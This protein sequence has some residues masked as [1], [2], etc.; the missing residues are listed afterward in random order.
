MKT[1]LFAYKQLSRKDKTTYVF[2]M[3]MRLFASLLDMLGLALVGLAAS[4]LTGAAGPSNRIVALVE[5]GLVGAGFTN[6]Y[7]VFG[8]AA[9]IF[10]LI[11]AALSIW[12]NS[13]VAAFLARVETEQTLK[14]F[15]NLTRAGQG[16]LSKWS[17]KEIILAINENSYVAYNYSFMAG[18]IVFGEGFLLT[19][20]CCFLLFQNPVLFVA[21]ALYFMIFALIV[22]AFVGRRTKVAAKAVNTSTVNTQSLLQDYLSSS[23]QVKVLG[24]STSF[25]ALYRKERHF[26]AAS[27]GVLNKLTYL[28]RYI[29]ETA[30]MLG[31]AIILLQRSMD[32]GVTLPASTVAVFVA[33]AF[34]LIASLL[35]LQASFAALKTVDAQAELTFNL[36]QAIA[37]PTANVMQYTGHAPR[38]SKPEI[39][40]QDV[41]FSYESNKTLLENISFTVHFG[42]YVA[43]VGKSGEGKSTLTDLLLGNRQVSLGKI[44]IGGSEPNEFI[45]ANP[46]KLGYVPQKTH[47]IRG[48]LLE[49]VL[50]SYDL[51]DIDLERVDEVLTLANLKDYVSSLPNGIHERLGEGFRELS[52]GQAQ[53]LSLA[54]AL[55]PKPEIL[56]LDEPTSSLDAQTKTD[57]NN[58]L[59]ALAG[60]MTIFAITHSRDN[61]ADYDRVLHLGKGEVTLLQASAVQRPIE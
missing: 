47:I 38:V 23:R 5:K 19:G 28:P 17:S 8:L 34:R 56:I 44:L 42:E 25:S 21:M 52:G 48:T 33:G 50:L 32:G 49:N 55:Y 58:V 61:I 4:M 39:Q 11:K 35:P 26:K 45:N 57:V 54:R 2:T 15:D 3:V 46:G 16:E 7:A 24:T 20:I 12:L 37:T 31:V 30:L 51:D 29:V 13:F 14:I 27:Q 40:V 1:L 10:F 41:S 22:S 6:T 36:E 43:L 60:S 9:A 53:R 59:K 18:S